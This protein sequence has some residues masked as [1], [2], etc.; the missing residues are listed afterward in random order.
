MDA[1]DAW[2]VGSSA[3]ALPEVV[4]AARAAAMSPP[5][6]KGL[7]LDGVLRFGP[8]CGMSGLFVAKIGKATARA[9]AV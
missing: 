7:A 1:A 5:L 4:M 8:S 6:P 2:R 9:T 3:G